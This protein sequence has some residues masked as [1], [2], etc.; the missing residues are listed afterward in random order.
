[1]TANRNLSCA[2]AS[3]VGHVLWVGALLVLT[4][5]V[6]CA[7]GPSANPRD[8]LEPFNRG[9]YHFNEVVDA[10][11]IKPVAIAYRDMAPK[12][13]RR[14][15]SNFFG[16]LQDAWSFVNNA[17]QLKGEAAM[18]SLFRFGVNSVFGLGGLL[19]VASEMR[20]ERH[21]K[22]FGHTLGYWGVGPGPYLVLPVFGPSTLRDAAARTVDLQGDI[23]TN[24]A[25]IPTRNTLTFVKLFEKRADLLN[26][27][28]MLE[29]VAL[30]KYT[31]VRDSYLQRRRS[32]IFD[33]NPPE[34]EF[35]D[36]PVQ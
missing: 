10:A 16:N 22:D 33:G 20:I 6:G 7:S 12:P 36:V 29:E 19:D 27:T 32:A 4:L 30:D 18:D 8:P 34:E 9:M 26:A 5:L 25:H 2:S 15:V 24:V 21:T 11:V 3:G 23:S 1:M 35:E 14:G 17:L 31:F 13:L 28:T